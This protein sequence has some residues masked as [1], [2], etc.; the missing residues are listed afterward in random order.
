MIRRYGETALLSRKAAENMD[1]I[2]HHLGTAAANSANNGQKECKNTKIPSRLLAKSKVRL[3]CQRSQPKA[4]MNI[5]PLEGQIIR[6]TVKRWEGVDIVED[7]GDEPTTWC[8]NV[9]TTPK[10]DREHK[11]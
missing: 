3:Q 4:K 2:E 10:K 1:L 11:G 7:L 9:V 5:C 8:S 6:E